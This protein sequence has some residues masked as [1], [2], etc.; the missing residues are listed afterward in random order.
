MSLL[1]GDG[2]NFQLAACRNYA[3]VGKGPV[4]IMDCLMV[5]RPFVH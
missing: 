5:N 3:D 1:Q 4:P 2:Y